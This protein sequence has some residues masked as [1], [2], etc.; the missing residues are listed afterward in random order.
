MGKYYFNYIFP[1]QA[2]LERGVVCLIKFL[3]YDSISRQL[4]SA[5]QLSLPG[6]IWRLFSAKRSRNFATPRE[7]GEELNSKS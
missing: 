5:V 7:K 4:Y 2:R 1:R 6:F 3:P